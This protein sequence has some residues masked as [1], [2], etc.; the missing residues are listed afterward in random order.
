MND[1][2]LATWA[3]LAAT[4]AYAE[5]ETI[6]LELG[7]FASSGPIPAPW[8]IMTLSSR[9]LPP[10]INCVN[11]TEWPPWRPRPMPAWRCWF[12]R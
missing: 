7:R 6:P 8:H 4:A 3:A 10:A 11:G 1:W 2:R 9:F 12:A 5:P